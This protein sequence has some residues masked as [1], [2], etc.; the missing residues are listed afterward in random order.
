MTSEKEYYNITFYGDG[1]LDGYVLLTQEE[2]KVISK[3]INS[4]NWLHLE[5]DGPMILKFN[6]NSPMTKEEMETDY[7]NR[8]SWREKS[9][10]TPPLDWD[11]INFPCDEED[12]EDEEMVEREVV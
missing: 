9:E 2:A 4:K 12:E 8:Y 7:A 11:D 3:V 1:E 6:V 10:K 5:E